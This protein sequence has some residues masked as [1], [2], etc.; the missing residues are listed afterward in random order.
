MV[1]LF[2]SYQKG[3][4]RSLF[5]CCLQRFRWSLY[6]WQPNR[7]KM[8]VVEFDDWVP[9]K[10]PGGWIFIDSLLWMISRHKVTLDLFFLNKAT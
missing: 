6:I 1:D 4:L 9:G 7:K 10:R 8:T 5:L 2:M 3:A